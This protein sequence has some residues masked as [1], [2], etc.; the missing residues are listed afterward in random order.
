MCAVPLL[1][2]QQTDGFWSF[3]Q[4]VFQKQILFSK[5]QRWLM[6]SFVKAFYVKK[7]FYEELTNVQMYF[8]VIVEKL[9]RHAQTNKKIHLRME[10]Q[11]IYLKVKDGQ[12]IVLRSDSPEKN[13]HCMIETKFSKM[14]CW[15]PFQ[16]YVRTS[17]DHMSAKNKTHFIQR[18][19]WMS[20]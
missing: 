14:T 11:E 13:K 7:I 9:W 17:N 15:S 4:D 20:N 19:E 18:S 3:K 16:D 8:Q 2:F 6:F 1:Q 12:N 10:S 5:C